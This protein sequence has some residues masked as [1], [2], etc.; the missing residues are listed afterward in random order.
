[1]DSTEEVFIRLLRCAVTGSDEEIDYS[2]VSYGRLWGLA[3]KHSLEHIIY[4]ELKKRGLLPKTDELRGELEKR[5]LL[6]RRHFALRLY[7]L[8]SVEE[9]LETHE[10]PFIL[11][12]GAFMTKLYPKP[13]M[14]S[15]ADVDVLVK[16]CDL[17]RAS[18]VL[19]RSGLKKDSESGH[20]IVF[21][22]KDGF[23][24]ELHFALIDE[25][26]FPR[27]EKILNNIW[28]Y[29]LPREGHIFEHVL[30]DE[31]FYFFHNAHMAK[32]LKTGGC[33]VRTLLDLW[34]LNHR[35]KFD[36]NKREKL[37]SQGGM[38]AFEH[39]VKRLSEI[40]FS[41]APDDGSLDDLASFIIDGGIYGTKK[42]NAEIRSASHDNRSSYYIRRIFL[43][44]SQLKFSYPILKKL[45][46]LLPVFWVVRWFR[47]LDPKKRKTAGLE[48]R[49]FKDASES[50]KKRIRRL[51]SE[52]EI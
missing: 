11:L 41:G 27:A 21:I 29:A 42:Q 47:L 40:W 12:K 5:W 36:E 18:E 43:P 31:A 34:I 39:R 10:I 16:P 15:G 24:T 28:D 38:G 17:G 8:N 23:H 26:V 2:D 33:G 32:H 37:L 14:R 7:A 4:Y 1:M 30:L 45:P 52:L 50:D 48:I 9:A 6:E 49:Y 3:K 25:G 19:I 35:V 13:W 22:S 44:Y 46:P 51:F 20:H